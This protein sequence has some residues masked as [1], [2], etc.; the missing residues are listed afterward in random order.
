MGE[1][2][3]PNRSPNLNHILF[4]GVNNFE[5]NIPIIKNIIERKNDHSLISSLLTNGYIAI[6][7]NT[8]KK[9]IPKLRFDPIL[10]SLCFMN[11][12]I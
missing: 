5:L 10:T 3:F 6:K 1:M 2:I 7:I 8:T 4:K 11:L 12:F 9:T